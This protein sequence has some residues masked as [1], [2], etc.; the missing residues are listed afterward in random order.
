[1]ALAKDKQRTSKRNN[2]NVV[3][4]QCLLKDQA[5]GMAMKQSEMLSKLLDG[6][7]QMRNKLAK[8]DAKITVLREAIAAWPEQEHAD[9]C[10]IGQADGCVCGAE[11]ANIARAIARKLAGLED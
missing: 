6:P 1:M 11:K 8:H 3:C 2:R 5:E 9:A 7:N 10:D 4:F